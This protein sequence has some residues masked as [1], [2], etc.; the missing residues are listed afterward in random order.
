MTSPR[1]LDAAVVVR[2]GKGGRRRE[3]GMDDWGWEH[4]R[5]WAPPDE[6]SRSDRGSASSKAQPAEGHGRPQLPAPRSTA[7]EPAPACDAA[8]HRTNSDTPTPSNSHARA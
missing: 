4:L 1:A 8:S 5:P 6:S 7:P 2:R 3:V